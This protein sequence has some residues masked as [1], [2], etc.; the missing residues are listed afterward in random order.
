MR[1][2]PPELQTHLDGEVTTLCRCWILTRK[3]GLV[4]G[5]TDHDLSIVIDGTVCIA[6]SGLEAG[7]AQSSLGLNVDNQEVAGAL[8]SDAITEMDLFAGKLDGAKMEV[9]LV[10]WMAPEQFV[11]EHVYQIG[12]VIRE[13][14]IFKAELRTQTAL[15]DQSTGR[16]YVKLCQADLGDALCGVDLSGVEFNRS[17][18]VLK[19][20]SDMILHVSGLVNVDSGW[21]RGGLLTWKSGNNVDLQIEVAEQYSEQDQYIIHLWKPMPSLPVAGDIFDIVVGCDKLFS[22]CKSKFLNPENFRGFPHMPGNDFAASY[23][24]NS[25]RMDGGALIT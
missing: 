23:A 6:N 24:N 5:F 3:D 4:Q 14:G 15:M 11:L 13:D 19:T 18:A 17:G 20:V 16:H 7:T 25:S 9:H 10:N 1:Q 12:D 22:T 21:F 8:Q 2:L